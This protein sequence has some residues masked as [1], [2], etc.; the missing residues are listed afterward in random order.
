MARKKKV[1]VFVSYSRHDE[2]LVKPLAGLLG[3]AAEDAVFL[4]VE[5]LKPGDLWEEKL[6]GAVQESSVFVLCWCCQ[7]EKSEFVAKE[8]R[9]ALTDRSKKLVPV[10]FCSTKLPADLTARQWIDLRGRVVHNCDHFRDGARS[11]ET[12]STAPVSESDVAIKDSSDGESPEMSESEDKDKHILVINRDWIR[13]YHPGP[14][15]AD[16]ISHY[17]QVKRRSSRNVISWFGLGLFGILIAFG[18]VFIKPLS[19]GPGSWL[20]YL[21]WVI[22]VGTAIGYSMA[23]TGTLSAGSSVG[24]SIRDFLEDDTA[25]VVADRA[26]SYFEELKTK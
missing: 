23:R 16:D 8:I 22:V 10:L 12:T 9:I 7:S 17:S 2:A 20:L 26:R 4:D 21:V 1:K 25:D 14:K 15:Q 24:E 5:Q 3:V 11:D 6:V 18:T 19:T 13:S